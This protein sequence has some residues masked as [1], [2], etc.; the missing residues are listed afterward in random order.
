MLM[1]TQHSE[2]PIDGEALREDFPIFSRTVRGHRLA[3]LDSAA[4]AQKPRAVISAVRAMIE[5]KYANVHRGAHFLG[6]EAT[7]AFEAARDKIARFVNAGDDYAV[8]FTRNATEAVN[9]VAAS[10]GRSNLR[11]GD[12][13]VLSDME[14]HANIVPWQL[15]MKETGARLR[16]VSVRDDGSFPMDLYEAALGDRTRLVAMTH[17]SNVLGTIPPI[18]EIVRLARER[19]AVTLVDGAQAVAHVPVDVDD[20]GADFYT[21]TGHKLYSPTGIGVLCGRRDL[22]DA[23]PPYQGGG[24]MIARVT[25]ER[26]TFREAPA[27]FEAGTPPIV[28]A[29]GLGAAVEYLTELGMDRVAAHDQELLAYAVERLSDVPG[30]RFYGTAPEKVGI[31]S[32]TLEAAHPHDVVTIVDRTGVA[33]RAG[34]HC[35]QPLMDRFGIAGTVRASFGVYSTPEDVDALAAALGTVRE[36]LG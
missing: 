35:A 17:C 21:F 34:H 7:D 6:Q 3:Y 36:I 2:A 22:L 5:E 29:V 1:E 23:M 20:V 18:R 12:E 31:L 27:R 4:S 13:I 25:F 33:V 9:L 15:V 30:V 16:V 14:H 19:G 11:E 28:E 32:F 26:T 24:E 10:W 8:V